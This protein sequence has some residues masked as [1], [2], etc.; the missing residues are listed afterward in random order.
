MPR[1]DV[2]KFG[3]WFVVIEFQS[4]FVDGLKQFTG[5]IIALGFSIWRIKIFTCKAFGTDGLERVGGS[6]AAS[7]LL[8][9]AFQSF[10]QSNTK[11]VTL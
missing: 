11:E 1:S 5:K 7:S 10:S 9:R 8:E 3:P 2:G 4:F 6:I